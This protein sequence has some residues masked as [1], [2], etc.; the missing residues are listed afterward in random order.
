MLVRKYT[1][2]LDSTGEECRDPFGNLTVVIPHLS[3]DALHAF[4]KLLYT[5]QSHS[6]ESQERSAIAELVKPNFRHL[7]NESFPEIEPMEFNCNSDQEHSPQDSHMEEEPERPMQTEK[8]H[9]STIP[10]VIEDDPPVSAAT[11]KPGKHFESYQSFLRLFET[12]C[13]Q[14]YTHIATVRSRKF[15]DG[16]VSWAKLACVQYGCARSRGKFKRR[17]SSAVV[18]CTFHV[19]ITFSEPLAKYC[20]MSFNNQHKNHETSFEY[21]HSMPQAKRLT[22][23]ERKRCLQAMVEGKLNAKELSEIMGR[24]TGK[25]IKPIDIRNLNRRNIS[26]ATFSRQLEQEVLP[27]IKN[28]R[29]CVVYNDE[30]KTVR[31]ACWQVWSEEEFEPGLVHFHDHGTTG[32]SPY[33]VCSLLMPTKTGLAATVAFGFVLQKEMNALSAMLEIFSPHP[34]PLVV[35]ASKHWKQLRETA[36][37]HPKVNFFTSKTESVKAV[38]N[39]ALSDKL[40][41]HEAFL[42]EK[43]L[44]M[45]ESQSVQ[46]YESAWQSVVQMAEK[47]PLLEDAVEELRTDWHAH[48]HLFAQYRL[49]DLNV[50]IVKSQ[51]LEENARKLK[52]KSASSFTSVFQFFM[53]ENRLSRHGHG[54][55]SLE[56][57]ANRPVYPCKAK[58]CLV[59]SSLEFMNAVVGTEVAETVNDELRESFG[60]EKTDLKMNRSPIECTQAKEKCSFNATN[61]LPCR[62]LLRVRYENRQPLVTAPMIAQVWYSQDDLTYNQLMS[63]R[64]AELKGFSRR[65]PEAKM[66][67]LIEELDKLCEEPNF[68]SAL[69]ISASFDEGQSKCPLLTGPCRFN[70]TERLPCMHL[71][72]VRI[73]NQEPLMQ[74]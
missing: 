22:P 15:K 53:R 66:R 16:R 32:Y 74:M 17:T 1:T 8:E 27:L 73:A 52:M 39:Y 63:Q 62:H 23:E 43:L 14:M 69:C 28:Y 10:T 71:F 12:Y 48:R 6:L 38:S 72:L 2:M 50:N 41:P 70:T 67:L 30:R 60:L 51:R 4:K 26:L 9:N 7:L 59:G 5:G 56:T 20:I 44:Q 68:A 11:F 29:H 42:K 19:S 61:L 25:N 24:E 13:R 55:C 45:V 35:I 18:G 3:L 47:D 21:Y 46:D 34:P 40:K 37:R 36:D 65:V 33:R 58:R 54:S 49:L 31:L 64:R 57:H